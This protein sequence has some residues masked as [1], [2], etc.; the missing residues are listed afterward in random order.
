M[1]FMPTEDSLVNRDLL[2][3]LMISEERYQNFM[4]AATDSIFINN[5]NGQF[6]DANHSACN[7]LGYTHKEIISMSIWDIEIGFSKETINEFSLKLVQGPFNVEG[8][9]RRKNGTTFPVDVRLSAFKSMGETMILAIVRDITEEKRSQATI[10]KLIYALEK[11]S[12]L[13]II[14]DKAG[15]I[16]YANARVIEQTGYDSEEIIGQNT[17]IFQSGKMPTETFKS[18]WE[19]LTNDQ[20]WHGELLNKNK[21]G[22]YYLVSANISPIIDEINN[23]VT[24]YLA[25]MELLKKV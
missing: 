3:Q 9:H 13:V 4:N 5:L 25:I 6:L 24:H 20:I 18:M 23:E 15:T 14:T 2:Y 12:S 7:S 8:C 1:K 21:K 17:R 16:E 19:Q 10:V 22:E 11:V